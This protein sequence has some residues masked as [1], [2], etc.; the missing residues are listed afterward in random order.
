MGDRSGRTGERRSRLWHGPPPAEQP[1][2]T[3]REVTVFAAVTAGGFLPPPGLCEALGEAELVVDQ[4]QSVGHD[5]G[6]DAVAQS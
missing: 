2:A 3:H 1:A 6:L 4:A 5:R